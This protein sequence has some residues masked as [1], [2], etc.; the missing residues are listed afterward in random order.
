MEGDR[1]RVDVLVH[2]F[3]LIEPDYILSTYIPRYLK[4]PGYV[5]DYLP[6]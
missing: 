3:L 5:L 1:Y 4:L 6:R 2:A